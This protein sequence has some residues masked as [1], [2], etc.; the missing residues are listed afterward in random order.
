M[1]GLLLL[2]PDLGADPQPGAD[3]WTITRHDGPNHLGLRC[4]ALPEHQ[5]ALIT[6][7]LC[8]LQVAEESAVEDT[9]FTLSRAYEKDIGLSTTAYL[10][11]VRGPAA[12]D[13]SYLSSSRAGV[14]TRAVFDRAFLTATAGPRAGEG[15]V[16]QEGPAGKDRRESIVIVPRG[17][18]MIAMSVF[19]STISVCSVN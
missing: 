13:C 8:A 16:L 4:N 2:C 5:T 15:S 6:S 14:V 12:F 1:T 19:V 7:V 9:L 11:E 17:A 10:K 3:P 18:K